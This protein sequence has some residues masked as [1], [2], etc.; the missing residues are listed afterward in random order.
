MADLS[1]IPWEKHLK[2]LID[3]GVDDLRLTSP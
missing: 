2:S 3:M 1:R